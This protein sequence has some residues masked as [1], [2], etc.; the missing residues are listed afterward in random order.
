MSRNEDAMLHLNWAKQAE[1]RGDFLAARMEY[2]K[3]V[4][5]W[6]QSDDIIELEKATREYEAF[7]RRD[8]VFEKLLAILLPIIDSNPSIL[9]SEIAKQ[10]ESVDWATLY[11]Y[12]RPIAREDVYYALYFAEKF[13]RIT[14]TKKGRSYELRIAI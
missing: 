11:D 12:N 7:V 1:K 8:P 4:E 5:S 2:L 10:A 6:K 14:R 9:Q 3:C 13:D